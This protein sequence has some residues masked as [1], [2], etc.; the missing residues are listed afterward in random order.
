MFFITCIHV[1]T[2]DKFQTLQHRF[3]I[4]K[5]MVSLLFEKMLEIIFPFIL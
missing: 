4:S 2:L 3:I 1:F 5:I